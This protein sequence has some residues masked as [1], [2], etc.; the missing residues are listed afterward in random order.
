[1][2]DITNNWWILLAGFGVAIVVSFIFMFLL[3]CLTGCI[4]WVSIFGTLLSLIGLGF[5]FCYSGGL[6]GDQSISYL[7]YTVPKIAA[8]QQYVKYY[9]FTLWGV[10]GVF[11][12]LILCLCNRIR[13]AVAVCKCAGR[14]IVEVCSVMF[15]P[16]FMAVV[17][18]ALWAVC[19]FVMIYLVSAADFVSN[20]DVFTSIV[21]Y[22]Q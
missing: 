2:V 18:V 10:A 9:G 22:T 14:F 13:L 5:L 3:R 8:D 17:T 6:F 20:G 19:L 12:I 16:I 15:V 7:G 1:M 21:D 4:V 11:L